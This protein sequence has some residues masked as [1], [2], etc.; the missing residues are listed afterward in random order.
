[1]AALKCGLEKRLCKVFVR[2]NPNGAI[3]MRITDPSW[4][5]SASQ[6]AKVRAACSELTCVNGAPILTID[7]RHLL[8]IIF[9]EH[10]HLPYRS[11]RVAH[12]LQ[13]F[14]LEHKAYY[15]SAEASHF[16]PEF[17]AAIAQERGCRYLI[18]DQF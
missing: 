15:Y 9:P 12:A 11:H 7:W 10:R 1:L 8:D 5:I 6:L 17:G 3:D 18:L 14:C 2:G 13:Q 4:N 16:R